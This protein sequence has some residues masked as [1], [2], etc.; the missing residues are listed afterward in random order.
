MSKTYNRSRWKNTTPKREV[1]LFRLLEQGGRSFTFL[2]EALK[3]GSQTL[4][5]YLE[6]LE[7]KGYISSKKHGRNVT[8][9]LVKSNPYVAKMLKLSAPPDHDVRVFNRAT[10]DELDADAFIN[11]WLNSMKFTF[12][13]LLRDYT[14]L[15]KKDVEETTKE[16]LRRILQVE[17]QDLTDIV[18]AY[19]QVLTARIQAGTIKLKRIE[20]FCER[21]QEEVRNQ[22]L[23]EH[24]TR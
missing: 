22:L 10:L 24:K 4:T 2:F 18:N 15:G 9:A 17:T 20:E 16:I 8:Y 21:M 13:N 12:V 1:A 7:G 14:F 19:G 3:W 5:F 6:T 11:D 23:K